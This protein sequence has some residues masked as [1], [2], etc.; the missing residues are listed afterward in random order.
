MSPQLSIPL[1]DFC[2]TPNT[3][4]LTQD[5][6]NST[7]VEHSQDIELLKTSLN[8]LPHLAGHLFLSVPVP[9][10]SE[11]VDC[12][13]LYRGLIF[14]LSIDHVS[15]DYDCAKAD[16]VHHFARQ[17]KEQHQPSRDKFIIPVLVTPKAQPQA[18]P[19]H[20]SEDLVA[21]TLCDTG[22]HLAA[23]LEHFSNQYKDDE[24]LA[25]TWLTER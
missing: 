20:V 9:N 18:S 14:V 13:V 16:Q 1:F 2:H 7:V 22:E 25:K 8:E 11:N 12:V 21:N 17:F 3:H 24:I 6:A 10:S 5:S 15:H 23:L 4:L 19:I